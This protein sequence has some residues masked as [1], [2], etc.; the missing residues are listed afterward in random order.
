VNKHWF[1]FPASRG[2]SKIIAQG[3]AIE[4]AALGKGP[5]HPT[6]FFPSGFARQRRTKP[7]GKKEGIILRP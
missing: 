7:E 6:S 2:G 5:P 4:V 3:K 1:A